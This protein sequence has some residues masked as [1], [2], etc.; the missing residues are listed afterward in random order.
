MEFELDQRRVVMSVGEFSR[1]TLGPHDPGEGMQGI[2]RA[3]LGTQW[4]QELRTRVAAENAAAPGTDSRG[5][6]SHR[7]RA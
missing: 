1:F 3:Q 2:W 7:C 6:R 5:R 4:H